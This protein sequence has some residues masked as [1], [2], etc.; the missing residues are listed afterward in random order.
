MENCTGLVEHHDG[1]IELVSRYSDNRN[2]RLTHS[3]RGHAS[4]V[5]GNSEVN[6]QFSA[7]LARDGVAA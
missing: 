5:E 3:K 7:D 2:L 4:P 6:D 1:N